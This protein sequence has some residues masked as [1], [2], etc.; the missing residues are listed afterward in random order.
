MAVFD[1]LNVLKQSKVKKN[2]ISVNH[3]IVNNNIKK[4]CVDENTKKNQVN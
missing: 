1:V 4:Y 3:L 2:Q